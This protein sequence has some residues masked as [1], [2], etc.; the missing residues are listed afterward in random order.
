MPYDKAGRGEFESG[1]DDS[2]P[3][4]YEVVN[5]V[6]AG[7]HPRRRSGRRIKEKDL[8]QVDFMVV[9]VTNDDPEADDKD[10]KSY[11]TLWGPFD[12]WAF[13]EGFLSYDYGV[14]GSLFQTTTS[15]R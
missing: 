6:K 13:V 8:P 11:N 4:K 5:W 12:D 15:A 10:K 1:E 9:R 3:Y 7:E 2:V 14:E